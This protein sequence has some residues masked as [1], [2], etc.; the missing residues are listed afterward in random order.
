MTGVTRYMLRQLVTTM[1]FVAFALTGVVWLSQSLRF[2]DLIVNRGLPF[3]TFIHLTLLLL[4]TFLTVILPVSLLCAV[5][6]TFHRLTID[7]ELTILRT[8]G[9][10]QFGL[11]R[12]ALILA[13]VMTLVCYAI[14]LYFMPLGFRAFKDRQFLIRSDYSQVLLRE[15]RFTS[16]S[17]AITVYVRARQPDGELR[18]ILVHDNRNPEKPVTMMAER[19]ALIKSPAGPRFLL[20]NGNRQEMERANRKLSLLY[21]DRYDFDLSNLVASGGLRWREPRERFLGELFGPPRDR[22]DMAYRGKLLAEGH[23]RLITPLYNIVF[24]LIGLAAMLAGEFNRRGRVRRMLI[25]GSAA[26]LFQGV[27]LALGNAIVKLPL[28]TPVV[29]AN[30]AAVAA[31]AAYVLFH[32]RLAPRESALPGVGSNGG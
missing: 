8:A 21:F 22:N 32:V 29:Y 28:L 3:L 31:A 19:G 24:A 7:S 25:G 11:A 12:P 4:P 16:L 23:Q 18:G 27:T 1:L 17:D 5:I 2:L 20:I 15:G 30:V 14:T 13:G 6:H 10:S 9:I 26:I